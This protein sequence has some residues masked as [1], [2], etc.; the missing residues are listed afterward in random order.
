MPT[1]N[2][3]VF[4]R[5]FDESGGM[6]LVIHAP[7]GARIAKAWGLAMRKRFCRSFDFELQATA[8]DDGLILSL[9]PQHSFPLE[10]MFPMLNAN[11]V[12]KL[13][14][15]ALLYVPTFQTR[16]RWNV[17]RA[18]L[19][20]RF[21]NGK[22]VPPALQ[23]FRADD[24]LTSVFPKLTG[25]QENI[26]GD[27]V[28]PDHPLVK[29]S[30]HDSLQEAH[31][32]EGLK[33]VLGRIQR[34]EIELLARDTREPSPFCYELLNANPY[35]FLDGGEAAERRTRAVATRRSLT[36]ESVSD[37][38][39]LDPEAIRQVCA[40]AQPFVRSID[41]L[42][43]VLL[44]RLVVP[45]EGTLG[46]CQSPPDWQP[47]F[48]DLRR[49]GRATT[50]VRADGVRY[51]VST[52]RLPAVQA[53]FPQGKPE[54]A[55][56]VPDTVRHDWDEIEARVTLLR[57]LMEVCGPTT[58]CEIGAYLS[59]PVHQV[60]AALEA[61]EGEGVVLRGRFRPAEARP[62]LP[63]EGVPALAG[64]ATSSDGC[65]AASEKEECLGAIA[66]V[67]PTPAASGE[68]ISCSHEHDHEPV[69]EV[70]KPADLEWCHRR[71]LARIH[72]LTMEGL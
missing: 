3:I 63:A 45:V 60:D 65:A 13:L 64:N 59:L 22:K 2:R 72:R 48:S 68:P 61:L 70:P 23:R 53:A 69:P 8:D 7:F 49:A 17:T 10:S 16:W 66:D 27:H 42:H 30:M 67:S 62:A 34:G 12:D 21:K 51:W 44:S 1:Q 50:F 46:L 15:Q 39:R 28:L 6:Q 31:D 52:E 47:L 58:S 26:T 56:V 24:L 54:P 40:E 71:L 57:G 18:L 38:G 41:E 43:D 14:E 36:V 37:L 25:C 11:N 5:F 32:L 35:A 29:Q 19:V 9:G 33:V 4:E 20:S 55:V